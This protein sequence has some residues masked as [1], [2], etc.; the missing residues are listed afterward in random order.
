MFKTT[1]QMWCSC[2]HCH[3]DQTH[4]H[5]LDV[6][7]FPWLLA[8]KQAGVVIDLLVMSMSWC[9]GALSGPWAHG[10]FQGQS[11]LEPNFIPS[12]S[13]RPPNTDRVHSQFWDR[14]VSIGGKRSKAKTL[15]S[16]YQLFRTY[17]SRLCFLSDVDLFPEILGPNDWE[18]MSLLWHIAPILLMVT[19]NR[20]AC[21]QQIEAKPLVHLF[22]PGSLSERLR[23]AGP[24][25][26]PGPLLKTK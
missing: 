24:V 8:S 14:G 18:G 20:Q 6:H 22:V 3:H 23:N 15:E 26:M 17:T 4:L 7:V 9:Q 5:R 16:E 10:M 19:P 12:P 2:H 11:L 25:D 1:D 13:K 21:D